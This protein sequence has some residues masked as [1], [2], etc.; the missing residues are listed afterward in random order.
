MWDGDGRCDRFSSGRQND[1]PARESFASGTVRQAPSSIQRMVQQRFDEDP[2]SG[3]ALRA[4]IGRDEG[5]ACPAIRTP[6]RRVVHD[7]DLP[8]PGKIARTPI[9]RQP[10]SADEAVHDIF[11]EMSEVEFN[12][13]PSH[14]SSHV[15]D[16]DA[17]IHVHTS[18]RCCAI[19]ATLADHTS[20]IHL[21]FSR[22]ISGVLTEPECIQRGLSGEIDGPGQVGHLQIRTWIGGR[23][24][25][26]REYG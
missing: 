1:V 20:R 18:W 8:V 7:E 3:S 9:H 16:E 12:F 21:D 13:N 22:C 26:D 11:T 15:W 25:T 19:H 5:R 10:F 23:L 24:D 4:S 6:S 2:G 17:A 14:E